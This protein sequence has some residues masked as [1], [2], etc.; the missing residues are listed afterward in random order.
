MSS[1]FDPLEESNRRGR[2]PLAARLRPRSL[3]E[4]VG[5]SHFLGEGRLLRRMIL[6]DRVQSVI[7]YGPPGVGKTS[8]AE[9]IA[10][11]STS[12]FVELNAAGCGIKEVRETLADALDR[13]SA[14]AERTV[15]F[16]DEIHHFN[17]SQQDILLPA[18]E[19][20]TI[21][22]IAATTQN[23]FFALNAPLI[24]RSQIF[25]FEPLSMPEIIGLL[26]RAMGDRERGLGHR[27]ISITDDALEHLARISDGDARRALTALEIAV[28]SFPAG[29]PIAIDRAVAEDSI[30]RKAIVHDGTGD[31]HFDVASAFIKSMRGS[32]P[33][34][35][36]YWLA[37]M[38]EAGEDPRFIARRLVI[39]ASEDI[40]NADPTA[41]MVAV[42]AH[43]A[44]EFVGLP[45]CRL[46]LAHATL[47]LA[48][49]PK[50]N[51]VISAIDAAIKDVKEGRTAQVPLALR[52]SHYKG[53]ARLGH[54]TGYK[55]PHDAPDGDVAQEYLPLDVR[56][57]HPTDRGHEAEIA[58]RLESQR[59]SSSSSPSTSGRSQH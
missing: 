18:L 20:G 1:L 25:Q 21:T 59:K 43:Q 36:V 47:H 45:E 14:N 48:T 23:P 38:L 29:E 58:R 39:F 9:V 19:K 32:D 44:S 35:A 27:A 4:F 2:L 31:E 57:Y 26:R 56:Y 37:R 34:A 41:L 54:G 5:Q 11:H 13:L 50:S 3:D 33:D 55:Y 51:A 42:A 15:L 16:L 46:N 28:L 22:M 8:L 49:A 24:S 6:A 30:Q 40:G 17:R 12:T 52:D 53:A 10:R 7:F